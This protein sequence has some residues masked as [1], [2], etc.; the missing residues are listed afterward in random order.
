MY[1]SS[2]N[3]YR[4]NPMEN[5]RVFFR[6]RNMLVKLILINVLVWLAVMFLSVLFDLYKTDY[7]K[8]VIEWLAV[9]ADT[10]QLVLRPWTVFTYMFLHYDFWHIL[11]NML[12]LFWFGKIFLEFLNQ[13]Q[14]LT[15]YI[16]GGLAGAVFYIVSFNMFP[17]FEEIYQHSVALGASASVMAI[18]VAISFYVPSYRINLLLIGPVKIFYI[19]LISIVLDVLMI[20]SSN[21]GG[22]LAHLGG[23]LWGFFSV[24]LLKNRIDVSSVFSKFSFSGVK[25]LYRRSRKTKF[26]NVFTNTRVKTDEEYNYEKKLN[27]K[28][29]DEILD[30]ISKSG[31]DNLTRQE[32]EFLF[33]TSRKGQ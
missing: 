14:L 20:K 27:Q 25:N 23:A 19:A 7:I 8:E 28:R 24:Y 9:P 32:K 26:K 4:Q 11:F 12:W 6:S 13:R 3:Q 31:Y 22:H 30:K 10:G 16:F 15:T 33:K 21:S 2:E 17:K 29:I 5:L 1:Y 18:V